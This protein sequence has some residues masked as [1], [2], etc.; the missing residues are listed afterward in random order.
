MLLRRLAIL[1]MAS[2][3]LFSGSTFAQCLAPGSIA[4]RAALL[5]GESDAY[6]TLAIPDVGPLVGIL[7]A[8]YHRL[9][10]ERLGVGIPDDHDH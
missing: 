5:Q 2:F 6:S 7:D 9:W 10:A 4:A 8:L 1:V 3:S